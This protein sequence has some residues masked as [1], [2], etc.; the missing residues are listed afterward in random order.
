MLRQT[1]DEADLVA[2]KAVGVLLGR[3]SLEDV[4]QVRPADHVGQPVRGPAPA[5]VAAAPEAP[6]VQRLA[7]RRVLL[8]LGRVSEAIRTVVT[9]T[10]RALKSNLMQALANVTNY[11]HSSLIL[12]ESRAV[13]ASIQLN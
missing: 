2:V 12:A 4:A 7:L 8:A 5:L 10:T 1:L 3:G 11:E 6:P 9:Q 13:A